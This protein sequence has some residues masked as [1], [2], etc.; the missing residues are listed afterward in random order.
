MS[1]S[2]AET[3][4]D[5]TNCAT[6]KATPHTTE[7][8]LV[9]HTNISTQVSRS[10]R[11]P[12]TSHTSTSGT[13]RASSGV[14]RPTTDATESSGSPVTWAS[15]TTGVPIA[16]NATGAVL[17]TSATTAARTG[18]K[19]R[20]TSITAEIATGAPKPARASSRAPKQNATTR[21]WMRGSS[22]RRPKE[23]RR[24]SKWRVRT[25]IR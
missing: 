14:W 1:A 25:V 15:V 22:E 9:T 24:M 11:R 20:A 23:R 12:S 2:W 18:S 4:L 16:P 5:A 17:A 13:T 3:K 6:A 19:P 10:P 21:A 8:V 7:V